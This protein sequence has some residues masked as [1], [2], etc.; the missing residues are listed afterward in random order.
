MTAFGDAFS[1]PRD[2]AQGIADAV[3]DVFTRT[4]AFDWMLLAV[5]FFAL[6]WL[7]LTLRASTR[8][9]PIEVEA[10]THD[11]Q[12]AALL[13][14]TGVLRERLSRIGLPSPPGVPAGAPQAD[15]I[16]AVEA[17]GVPQ[18]AL[19]ARALQALPRPRP[20]EYKVSGVL[21]G[22]E[23]APPAGPQAPIAPG[24]GLPPNGPGPCSLRF[25]VRPARE[26]A[27]LLRTVA[28]QWTHETTVSAAAS[29]VYL[30][31]SKDAS[32]AFP[33]WARWTKQC[34]L[35][36]Y[37]DG[38]HMRAQER[39]VDAESALTRAAADDPFNVLPRLELANL[40]EASIPDAPAFEKASAQSAALRRYLDVAVDH[41]SL[42]QPRYRAAI[43]ASALAATCDGLNATQQ[44]RIARQL[45]IAGT[46]TA[47][48][49]EALR[50]LAARESHGVRQ[51]LR[52]WYIAL[53]HARPRT[54]FEPRSHERRRL[55]HTVRI[56]EHCLR[57]RRFTSTNSIRRLEVTCRSFAVQVGILLF[58]RGALSWQAH[59]NAA[60]FDALLLRYMRTWPVAPPGE[61]PTG[62]PRRRLERVRARA[63]RSLKRAREEAGEE[64]PGR[65]VRQDPDQEALRGED[66]WIELVGAHRHSPTERVAVPRLPERPRG[67]ELPPRPWRWPG[68]R[69]VA[70]TLVVG[71]GIAATWLV[72]FDE[73]ALSVA[74][75]LTVLVGLWR[76]RLAYWERGWTS[77][78][79]R[80]VK[81]V[82]TAVDRW[83]RA[84]EG[85]T[86]P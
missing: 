19:F 81:R 26:G 58:G 83:L 32:G 55:S 31:I 1:G 2:V 36:A 57:L 39:M 46:G 23:P 78:I 33:V 64:L 54:A 22:T 52:P 60:C 53:R 67:K 49:P 47:P 62:Y 40:Y 37:V 34:A 76:G 71:A 85:L 24:P 13:A 51:L 9:G 4:S 63:L 69:A 50:D 30:H 21:V 8:V 86:A 28:G 56:S 48:L 59:Y 77:A 45:D 10:L 27:P 70:W 18:G 6:F 66:R 68:L 80:V 14:L 73:G 41:P 12:G 29:V 15:L 61:P 17:S 75:P 65:W 5:A 38:C 74:G 82:A 25:W 72:G 84:P 3:D 79:W 42:T 11:G 16:A 7:W 44:N 35:E 20:R 43:V